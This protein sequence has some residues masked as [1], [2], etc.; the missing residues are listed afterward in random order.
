[1][2][3]RIA[4][5]AVL[6][7]WLSI[8]VCGC[9]GFAEVPTDAAVAPTDAAVEDGKI[10]GVDSMVDGPAAQDLEAQDLGGKLPFGGCCGKKED[11]ASGLCLYLGSGPT[12]C[13]ETC[14]PAPDSCPVGFACSKESYCVP[15]TEHY[16]CGPQV[17]GAKPQGFGGCCGKQEDCTSGKCLSAGTGAYFCSQPCTKDPDNC[18]V[19]YVC[20]SSLS[21]LPS[22]MQS[23]CIFL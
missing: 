2:V 14:T 8:T 1:M 16:V 21:C 20:S 18:P 4:H 7:L 22:S 6:P 15:P 23:T 19:K 5:N 17:T 3:R 11:C 10:N 13:S 12:Y 9:G